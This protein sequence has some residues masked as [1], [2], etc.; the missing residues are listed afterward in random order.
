MANTT[1]RV[2]QADVTRLVKAAMAAGLTVHSV[3]TDLDGKIRVLTNA[4]ALKPKSDWD[5]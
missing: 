4:E 2:K 3:E 5:E 1:A